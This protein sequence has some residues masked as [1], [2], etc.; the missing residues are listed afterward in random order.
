MRSG[1]SDA[2]FSV[3]TLGDKLQQVFEAEMKVLEVLVQHEADSF[4]TV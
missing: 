1:T 2:V 4:I 3:P